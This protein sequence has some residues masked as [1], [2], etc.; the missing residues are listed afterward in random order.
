ML[1]VGWVKNWTMRV[2]LDSIDG[3]SN[4]EVTQERIDNFH[5]KYA[6][7]SNNLH[8]YISNKGKGM[9]VRA[10]VPHLSK[11]LNDALWDTN[12][13]LKKLNFFSYVQTLNSTN[14]GNL[15]RFDKKDLKELLKERKD[16]RE[17]QAGYIQSRV[18]FKL[19][20]NTNWFTV[21]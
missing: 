13:N 8:I 5:N 11:K 7:M 3:K 2:L 17:N 19:R 10:Y 1:I 21:K 12:D 18:A 15:S 4:Q 16:Y 14:I 9:L 20:K 6:F